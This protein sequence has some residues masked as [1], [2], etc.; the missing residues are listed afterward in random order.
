[1]QLKFTSDLYVEEKYIINMHD[2]TK[3]FSL[4]IKNIYISRV[5]IILISVTFCPKKGL[6]KEIINFTIHRLLHL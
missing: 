6:E 1:M 4:A 3:M 2:G 5:S